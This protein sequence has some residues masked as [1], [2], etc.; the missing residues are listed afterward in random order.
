M[1]EATETIYTFDATPKGLLYF[2][3]FCVKHYAVSLF[4]LGST[5]SQDCRGFKKSVI[6]LYGRLNRLKIFAVNMTKS[7]TSTL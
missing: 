7:S 5:Y 4:L 2:T 6:Q 1:S 3:K